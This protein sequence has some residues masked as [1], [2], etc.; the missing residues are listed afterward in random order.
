VCLG[1]VTYEAVA[2]NLGYAWRDPDTILGKL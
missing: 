2:R 1:E